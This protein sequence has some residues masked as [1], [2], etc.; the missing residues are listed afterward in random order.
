MFC[1]LLNQ[2]TNVNVFVQNY[3]LDFGKF[4]NLNLVTVTVSLLNA[5]VSPVLM[6]IGFTL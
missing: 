1:A 6:S 3:F 5:A 2:H 4:V